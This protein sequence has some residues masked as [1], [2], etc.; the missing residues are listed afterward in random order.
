MCFAWRVAALT[1]L[2]LWVAL[3]PAVVLAEGC[4][5]EPRQVVGTIYCDNKFTLWVNGTRVAADP[6]GFTPHQAVRV[7]FEWDGIS[8]L[9]YAIQCE[10]FASESGY[11]YIES[12]WPQLGDGALIAAFD[13]GVNTVTSA[14]TWRTHTVTHGPT[15]ASRA[16][17]CSSGNLA[18][19]VVENRGEPRGWT[20]A[21]F[22]D[23]AWVLATHY[24]AAQ[25]GWGRRPTWSSA[26]G[27]CTLT[28]PVDRSSLGCDASVAKS[29][30][31]D[32][33]EVFSRSNA[34]FIWA[35]DLER[36]NR[37]LFR[38]TVRCDRH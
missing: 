30:C 5:N 9:T 7:A 10:D 29:Q 1:A 26:R 20:Q 24:S 4:P 38:Y 34:E 13:D 22:D 19:C 31:L 12:G 27:C 21:D 33:R 17:G 37:V 25:A 15:D 36:D 8:D 14:R 6:I 11:E 32:P 2:F 16:A 23:S 35:A 3:S 18:A 28:S